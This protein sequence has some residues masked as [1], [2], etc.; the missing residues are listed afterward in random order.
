MTRLY[1]VDKIIHLIVIAY[2][3][4]AIIVVLFQ[5]ES[6]KGKCILK[7][8]N[9]V[10]Q[11]LPPTGSEANTTFPLY[12]GTRI[13]IPIYLPPPPPPQEFVFIKCEEKT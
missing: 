4:I 10:A 2:K 3:Y 5:P 1:F 8:G 7:K 11:D 12:P 13:Y 6:K 9:S